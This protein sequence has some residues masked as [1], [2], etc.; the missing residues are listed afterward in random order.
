[1]LPCTSPHPPRT[2]FLHSLTP[3]C[4]PPACVC[5]VLQAAEMMKAM[6]AE[7]LAEVS[8]MAGAPA[9][10]PQALAQMQR[11]M[12]SMSPD[13]MDAMV[14]MSASM[15]AAGP[16][17]MPDPAAMAKVGRQGKF[18]ERVHPAR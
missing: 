9:M 12:A 16:G 15:G 6:P 2:T 10:D 1:M 17:G 3:F 13:Q 18:I 7:Q 8:R 14:R 5:V 11:S 4:A